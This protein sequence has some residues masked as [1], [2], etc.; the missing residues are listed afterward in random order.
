MEKIIFSGLILLMGLLTTQLRVA[1]A[2]WMQAHATFYG[3]SDAS[4]TMGIVQLLFLHII[5]VLFSKSN[6]ILIV[7]K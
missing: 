1:S 5:S 3:G 2:S 4:G 6:N 7:I